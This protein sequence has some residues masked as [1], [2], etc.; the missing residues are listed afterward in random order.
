M[1]NS[2][3][4]LCVYGLLWVLP[5]WRSGL[6]GHLTLSDEDLTSVTQNHWKRLNTL[7]H[8]KVLVGGNRARWMGQGL[9]LGSICDLTPH[10]QV[11][12]GATVVLIPQLH[13]GGTVSQS[14]E[15]T[16]CH[17]GESES[18]SP[19]LSI[20]QEPQLCS[21]IP[22]L[23]SLEP[24]AGPEEVLAYS[25]CLHLGFPPLLVSGIVRSPAEPRC[26]Y[27]GNVGLSKFLSHL[28]LVP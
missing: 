25:I 4:R 11:P 5:E 7:Q 15:Q 23:E 6:A 28:S 13:N 26:G 22:G 2:G 24:Q 8:Y 12:D 18:L 1:R 14:L 17:S 19:D 16:G 27:S 9:P 10:L 20:C 21:G 3:S